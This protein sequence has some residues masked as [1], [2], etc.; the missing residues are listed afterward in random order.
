M[1]MVNLPNP[2]SQ[3]DALALVHAVSELALKGQEPV[4]ETPS[5]AARRRILL[6]R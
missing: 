2:F 3:G 6:L 5:M 1:A 4:E